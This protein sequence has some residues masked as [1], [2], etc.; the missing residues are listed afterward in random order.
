MKGVSGNVTS[1]E[2]S[3]KE[4]SKFLF[5]FLLEFPSFVWDG[6]VMP[7]PAK[8]SSCSSGRGGGSRHC[9]SHCPSSQRLTGYPSKGALSWVLQEAQGQQPKCRARPAVPAAVTACG[10]GQP[11]RSWASSLRPPSRARPQFCCFLYGLLC[12]DADGAPMSSEERWPLLRKAHGAS[13]EA[14]ALSAGSRPAGAAWSGSDSRQWCLRC[15]PGPGA[16]PCRGPGAQGR[17]P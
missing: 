8:A 14:P 13:P 2:M 10:L 9:G 1:H 4:T 11:W 3:N 5:L 16:C 12:R 15:R 6:N 17:P 7:V